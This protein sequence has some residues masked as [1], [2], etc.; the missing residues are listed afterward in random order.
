MA[1]TTSPKQYFKEQGTIFLLLLGQSTKRCHN[2]FWL[3]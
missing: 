3:I 2:N 1:P